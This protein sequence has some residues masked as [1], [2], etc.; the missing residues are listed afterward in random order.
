MESMRKRIQ[1]NR[2]TTFKELVDQLNVIVDKKYAYN[3]GSI[4]N[5]LP[6]LRQVDPMLVDR[7]LADVNVPFPFEQYPLLSFSMLY[8]QQP[9][10]LAD[11]TGFSE[12]P[13][14][15]NFSDIL[16]PRFFDPAVA[17]III[18]QFIVCHLLL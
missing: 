4:S 15:I 16:S 2:S 8:G 9:V 6:S 7:L 10:R 17:G 1:I 11:I 5:R 13:T 12:T 14:T 3:N 18:I